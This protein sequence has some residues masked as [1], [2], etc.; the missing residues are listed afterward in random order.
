[1]NAPAF[2]PLLFRGGTRAPEWRSGGLDRA[3]SEVLEQGTKPAALYFLALK[4]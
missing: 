2:R 1:M 4:R 3:G